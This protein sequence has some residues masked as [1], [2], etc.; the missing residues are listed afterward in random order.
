MSYI[1]IAIIAVVVLGALLGLW[2]GF[3]KTLI[4]FFGWLVSFLLAFFLTRVIADALLDVGA[5]R[6][7][8]VGTD[9]W[10]L[11]SW[12]YGKLPDLSSVSG[13][14]AVLLK[15][16]LAIAEAGGGD[17]AE[18]VA[19]LLANGI[20]CIIVCI[21]LFIAIRLLLLLFTMFAN[22]MTKNRFVGALNRLLGLVLG[23]VKGLSFIVIIM[24]IMSFA[25][26]LSFMAPVRAQLDKS[27]LGA[28]IY[29]QVYKLTD[30][31][32]S[33]DNDTL[34]KLRDYMGKGDK[35][36][37][38]GE[39]AAYAGTYTGEDNGVTYV[40][41]LKADGTFTNTPAD[42][43]PLSGTFTVEEDVLTFTY[44]KKGD[45]EQ[46][47]DVATMGE[48]Y[49]RL[50]DTYFAKEG[51]TPPADTEQIKL[52]GAYTFTQGETQYTLVLT[53]G[54]TPTDGTYVL[55]VIT[56]GEETKTQDTYDYDSD[57]KK[58]GL[59]LADGT[60]LYGT[61]SAD[62]IEFEDGKTFVKA[63][64]TPPA[65][66]GENGEENPPSPPETNNGDQTEN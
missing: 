5:I 25:M 30:K 28:P 29:N 24:I 54:D 9:G 35:E 61:V 49:F 48:G 42:G 47:V 18:N 19:L 50:W 65:Q 63:P 16:I 26:G 2:K 22:A 6:Q 23:A 11:Y 36:E 21:G 43:A 39:Y 31:F 34:V 17:A 56:N 66:D 1:D 60:R 20:F 14:L 7:F 46:D 51:V 33:G 41:V 40:F 52:G 10:S 62:T 27:V 55:T 57:T 38:E 8:V 37:E 15:P 45:E 32:L 64:A 58:L 59:L 44:E 12:I 53:E 13:V 4:S 3:F